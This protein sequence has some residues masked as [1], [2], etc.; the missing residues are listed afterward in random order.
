MLKNSSFLDMLF[1]NL[2][3]VGLWHVVS[4]LSCQKFPDVKFDASKGR[5]AARPWEHGGRWYR[6]NLKIQ[7]WKDKLPQHI[8]KGGFSKRHFRGDSIGYLD[9]FILETC[10]GEWMHMKNCICAVVTLIINPLLVG[11]LISSFI[12]IGNLPFA[13]VQRYNR[14]RL[15]ILRKRRVR[16]RLRSAGMERNVVT[17]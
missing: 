6:D 17:A 9:Q 11:V 4:F 5:Y 7:I 1:W 2:L 10:R 12:L 3:I 16:E 15:Q 14:F 8:G 13:L